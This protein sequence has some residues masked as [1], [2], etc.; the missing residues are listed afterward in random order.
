[1]GRGRGQA[2]GARE[3]GRIMEQRPAR[4]RELG[5]E[6]GGFRPGPG[7]AITDVPGVAVGHATLHRGTDIRTGV[8]AI[9]RRPGS[10][11]PAGSAPAAL[12]VGNGYGKLIG[13]TQVAEL[14][15]I[16]TPVLAHR[17]AV[18]VPGR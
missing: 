2:G 14:G 16:E 9:G 13:S 7:N 18:G 4:A 15:V 6:F 3:E 12:A 1:M 8:T 5:V 10:W 17:D 11:R